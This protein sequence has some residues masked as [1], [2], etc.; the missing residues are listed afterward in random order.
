MFITGISCKIIEAKSL[1]LTS[2]S[3]RPRNTNG[4]ILSKCQDLGTRKDEDEDL[5]PRMW[6]DQSYVQGDKQET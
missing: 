1:D 5:N 3:H 2:P 6:K 4:F